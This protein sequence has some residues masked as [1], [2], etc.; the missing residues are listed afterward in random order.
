MKSTIDLI[1]TVAEAIATPNNYVLI[2]DKLKL[3]ET[4]LGTTQEYSFDISP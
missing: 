2:V 1:G 4:L 3:R